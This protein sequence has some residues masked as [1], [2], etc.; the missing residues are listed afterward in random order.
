MCLERLDDAD[1]LTGNQP[2]EQSAGDSVSVKFVDDVTDGTS[3]YGNIGVDSQSSGGTESANTASNSMAARYIGPIQ[4]YYGSMV[5]YKNDQFRYLRPWGEF[6]DQKRFSIPS[7]LEAV[8]RVSRNIGHFYVNY[9]VMAFLCS[10]YILLFNPLFLIAAAMT[11]AMYAY[12]RMRSAAEEP[13][14][15]L[16]RP[17]TYTQG[18]IFL[19]LFG[20]LSFF[21]TNGSSTMF[22]L[23]LSSLGVVVAHAAAREPTIETED[24]QFSFS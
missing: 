7:K 22:W 15:V 9:V 23:I 20:I 17:M 11:A 14:F 3:A 21:V 2:S 16:G 13:L 8:S 18:Y 24:V 12:V 1:M 19:A 6:F 5:T 4:Q 10:S